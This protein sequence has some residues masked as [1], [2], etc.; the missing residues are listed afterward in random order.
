MRLRYK[1]LLLGLLAVAVYL[2]ALQAGYFV[3]D[4]SSIVLSFK[5]SDHE[6]LD[7][8]SGKTGTYWRPLI[9]ASYLLDHAVADLHPGMMHLENILLHALNTLLVFA[10]ARL[11]IAEDKPGIPLLIAALFCLH[12]INTESVNW[13][14]ARTDPLA[15]LFCLAGVYLLLLWQQKRSSI[16][17]CYVAGFCFFV[18]CLAKEVAFGMFVGAG[19]YLAITDLNEQPRYRR[20]ASR[21]NYQAILPIVLFALLYLKARALVFTV[22]DHGVE[23][24]I[25]RTLDDPLLLQVEK[26]LIALGFYVKKLLVPTPLTFA[27]DKVSDLYLYAGLATMLLALVGLFRFRSQSGMFFMLLASIAPALVNAVHPI[28]WTPY[29]ER[30][31]YLPAALLALALCQALARRSSKSIPSLL[32][33]AML[34]LYYLPVTVHRNLLWANQPAFLQLAVEQTSDNAM[35]RNNYGVVLE[36]IGEIEQ[37]RREFKVAG[38]LDPDNEFVRMNLK[39]HAASTP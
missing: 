28:A 35:L 1:I 5:D 39:K 22:N 15:A 24:V 32:L 13:I 18:G 29:A 26:L 21:V 25:A 30:Y 7:Y 3:F 4:D 16:L 14:S 9:M 6:F 12:P 31:L 10:I 33:L 17:L 36:S 11:I 2:P 8:F 23:G 34:L 38:S 19:L 20:V 37:A 27:I